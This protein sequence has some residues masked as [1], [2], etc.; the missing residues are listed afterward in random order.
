MPASTPGK[1]EVQ[2][3]S[4]IFVHLCFSGT[5]NSVLTTLGHF[6]KGQQLYSVATVPLSKNLLVS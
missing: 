1:A 2:E 3:W 5:K 6:I 4:E